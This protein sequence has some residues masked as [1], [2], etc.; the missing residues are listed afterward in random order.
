MIPEEKLCLIKKYLEAN[1]PEFTVTDFFNSDL[2][3]YVF[4]FEEENKQVSIRRTFLESISIPEIQLFLE[5]SEASAATRRFA[6]LPYGAFVRKLSV[7]GYPLHL[8]Q[9]TWANYR[10]PRAG[11]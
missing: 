6:R 9:A 7:S 4:Y 2:M 11:L 1:F 10:T 3:V 5:K 8:P